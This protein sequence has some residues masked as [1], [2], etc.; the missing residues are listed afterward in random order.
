MSAHPL[1]SKSY[2]KFIS[3]VNNQYMGLKEWPSS[4]KWLKNSNS[5]GVWLS[6]EVNQADSNTSITRSVALISARHM[7]IWPYS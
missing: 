3:I 5:D 1:C 4:K 2:D 6:H 7:A